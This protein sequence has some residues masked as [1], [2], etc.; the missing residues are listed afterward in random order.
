M[1]EVSLQWLQ[2]NVS[3]G[4]KTQQ[5]WRRIFCRSSAEVRPNSHML[6]SRTEP[7]I[8]PNASAEVRRSPNFGPSL[9]AIQPVLLIFKKYILWSTRLSACVSASI[10]LEPLDRSARNFVCRSPVA[11]ARSSSGGVRCATLC[12]SGFMDDVTFGGNERDTQRWRLHR[13][14]TAMNGVAIPGRSLMSM[15]A[16]FN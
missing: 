11:M 15:N 1:S 4:H 3:G 8:R 10:S 16:C 9:L 7:N 5:K 14:A 12:T 6:P 13:A 2:V